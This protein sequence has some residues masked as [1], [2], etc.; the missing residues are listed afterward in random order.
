MEDDASLRALLQDELE[1]E[2]YRVKAVATAEEAAAFLAR[3]SVELVLSDLR[4]P[5]ADGLSLVSLVRGH[6]PPPALLIITAFGT[7]QQAVAALKAGADDFLTK[8]IDMD[9]LLLTVAKLLEN[10]SL[11]SE[12]Q[13][14]RALLAEREFHGIV[15]SSAPMLNLF[16]QVRRVASAAG[17]VLIQGESGTGKE[18]VARAIHRESER[19]QGP[20]LTVNCGGI[21]S[22]LMESEFFG[23]TSGAFTGAKNSRAGLFQ[24]AHGGTLLLDEIGE[25]PVALQAKLL[26][27]LQDGRVRPVGSDREHQVDVRIIAATNRNLGQAVA[28]GDFREDLYYRLETFAL[29]VPPL[30]ERGDDLRQLANFFLAR[31]AARRSHR[32]RGFSD[33]AMACLA[34]YPFPG[35]VRELENAVE[36]AVTFCDGA[37]IEPSHLPARIVEYPASSAVAGHHADARAAGEYTST[38]T[39]SPGDWLITID[40]LQRRHVARVLAHTGGN[41]RQAAMILGITRRTLY[42]WLEEADSAT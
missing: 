37:L 28:E 24:E 16:G 8:P 31:F 42:R 39:S 29:Q 15:A 41:K 7:V 36:R 40:E 6:Q 33:A 30:R 26:R 20:Y 34:R 38:A 4:L 3:D 17:P 32:I 13:R 25:M 11:H 23:H 9:H 21:P 14:Y 19:Q 27:V 5:G 1:T 35:N 10:R 18:L 22:E 2:G 12:V